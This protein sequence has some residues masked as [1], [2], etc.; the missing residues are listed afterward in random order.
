MALPSGFAAFIGA[1]AGI[2]ANTLLS[3]CALTIFPA[4]EGMRW[5]DADALREYI[6]TL[7]L[8]AFA[9]VFVAHLS[10]A[11]AG[12]CVSALL[13]AKPASWTWIVISVFSALGG[14]MNFWSIPHP[15]WMYSELPLYFVVGYAG[16]ALGGYMRCGRRPLPP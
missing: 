8:A 16:A 1:V 7:P 6:S 15:T 9:L 14:A 13:Q 2:F 10:Q 11:F 3:H 12:S 5:D 4:P